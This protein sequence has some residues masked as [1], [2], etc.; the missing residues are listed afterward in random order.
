M[1]KEIDVVA[2][3]VTKELRFPFSVNPAI[4]IA[5]LIVKK[6]RLPRKPKTPHLRKPQAQ[7]ADENK[8]S[9]K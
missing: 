1:G 7:E 2:T 8:P 4:G 9:S 5:V 3:S 6:F